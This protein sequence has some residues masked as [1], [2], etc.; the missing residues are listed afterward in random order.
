MLPLSV[1]PVVPEQ[2]AAHYA[3][4]LAYALAQ[5]PLLWVAVRGLRGTPATFATG[6]VS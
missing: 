1:L 3:A 5:L 2:S 4:L 6:T